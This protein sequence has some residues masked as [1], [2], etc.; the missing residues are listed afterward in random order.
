LEV[1]ARRILGMNRAALLWLLMGLA[2]LANCSAVSFAQP[3]Q[4][5]RIGRVTALEGR[6][7][8]LRQGRFAAQPLAMHAAIFQE[9]LIQTD[10]ASKIRIALVDDT[11][12]SLGPQSR[13]EMRQFV[14]AAGQP[15]RTARLAVPVGL[16]RAII[17]KLWPQSTTEVITPTAI[18]AI[19][20]TDFMG[21]VTAESTAIVVLEGTVI[22]SNVRATF[23]GLATLTEGLGVTVTADQPPPAPTRW[24]TARIEAL[25]RATEVR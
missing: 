14:Y 18:A 24:S 21:E 12:I 19:R 15:T 2:L 10:A 6:A 5:V 16:F 22:V 11:V 17:K 1:I 25:R 9:D 23:R 3:P 20:G 4:D 7:T 8:V 13:L